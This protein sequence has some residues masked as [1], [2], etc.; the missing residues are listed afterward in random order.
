MRDILA[1]KAA[2]TKA[3]AAAAAAEAASATQQAL[4]EPFLPL[5]DARFERRAARE[6]AVTSALT[7]AG[8]PALWRQLAGANALLEVVLGELRSL[9]GSSGSDSVCEAEDDAGAAFALARRLFR[10]LG[11]AANVPLEPPEQT[12]LI[13]SLLAAPWPANSDHS[14]DAAAAS[15]AGP[16]LAAGVPGAGGYDAVFAITRG[17][18]SVDGLFG[19]SAPPSVSPCLCS[20]GPAM[21]QSGA[22]VR[23]EA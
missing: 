11:Q 7:S 16:V 18:H 9:E 1:W 12:A 22:G 13:D 17:R 14:L 19:G 21:G 8:G 6:A 2:A 10:S 20:C 4:L 23:L 3:E 5:L 15:T